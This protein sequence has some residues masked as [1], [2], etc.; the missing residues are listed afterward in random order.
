MKEIEEEKPE[1]AINGWPV[2][3]FRAELIATLDGTTEGQPVGGRPGSW[4]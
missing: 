3:K 2:R 4:L 1:E